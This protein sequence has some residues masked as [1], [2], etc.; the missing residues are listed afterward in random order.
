MKVLLVGGFEVVHC[1]RY[2]SLLQAENCDVFVLDYSRSGRPPSLSYFRYLSGPWQ[3]LRLFEWLFSRRI[4]RE[5]S[6]K[7]VR[8]QLR[9]LF[10]LFRPDIVHV[11]W[12]GDWAWRIARAGATP[13][14]LTAWG[15]DINQTC[16]PHFDPGLRRQIR[17]ALT[18]SDLL[19][20]DSDDLID[21]AIALAD[22]PLKSISLPI[23]IDTKLFRPGYVEEAAEWRRELGI[24]HAATVILSPR[25]L[26]EEYG[27]H[28]ILESFATATAENGD[29]K[30]L[31]MKDFD[32]RDRHYRTSLI[33]LAA[34]R[35]VDAR[36]RILNQVDY[37]KLPILYSMADLA[38][39][40]P[41]A[42]AFPVTFLE[43]L[44]CELP[45]L[46]N[47]LP[48][49]SSH[50][51]ARHFVFTDARTVEALRRRLLDAFA[52]LPSLLAMASEGGA[53]VREKFDET[54][55]R[56]TLLESYRGLVPIQ[57]RCGA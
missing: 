18:L 1:R 47:R 16:L 46:T 35:G 42:D 57:E 37:S 29:D 13:L 22:K 27:H 56:R 31:V 6:E 14:V 26:R 10:A 30:Y 40:F 49:Y 43:C 15:T 25:A 38:V 48:A 28:F 39:N 34:Q 9:L 19:I 44:A 54:V 36:V 53:S 23:G 8:L 5:L 55:T 20:A 32:G 52:N 51:L 21:R 4:A 3:G 24:P 11:Q 17:E 41:I 2:L 33:E 50:G 7:F 12:I 45:M